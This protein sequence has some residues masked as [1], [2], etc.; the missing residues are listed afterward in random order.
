MAANVF[1]RWT[2]LGITAQHQLDERLCIFAHKSRGWEA[3]VVGL[4]LVV[5]RLDVLRLKRRTTHN[6][7]VPVQKISQV[8]SKCWANEF[9]LDSHYAAE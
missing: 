1:K 9:E 2:Q 6:H 5:C 8:T 7:C 3:V 4:D